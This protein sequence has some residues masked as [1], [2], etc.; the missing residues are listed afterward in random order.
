MAVTKTLIFSNL[1]IANA[2]GGAA[3]TY[4]LHVTESAEV[5]LTPVTDTVDDG[6][7]LASAYDVSFTV[8]V[9]NTTLLSD[10]HVYKD[11]STSP[12]LARIIFNPATGGQQLNV[13]NV[14][15]N[16]NRDFSGN[17]TAIRLTG[18]KRVTNAANGV[19]VA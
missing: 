4:P 5:T 16:A 2:T 12:V 6:Q 19:I 14:Y 17:R 7:T 8:D 1:T 10:P 18:T 11:A 15:I 9:F 13:E 3:N